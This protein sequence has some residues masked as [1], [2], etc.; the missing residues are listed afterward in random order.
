MG[1]IIEIYAGKL[2]FN[3]NKDCSIIKRLALEGQRV[4][5]QFLALVEE[6][7]WQHDRIEVATEK[8]ESSKV[9]ETYDNKVWVKKELSD[10]CRWHL[11]CGV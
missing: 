7:S 4:N 6:Y 5:P 1:E 8:N 11:D 9:R 3:R 2:F 10:R